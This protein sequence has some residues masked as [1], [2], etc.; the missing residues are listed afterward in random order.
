M[1]H[2]DLSARLCLAGILTTLGACHEAARHGGDA[3]GEAAVTGRL[4]QSPRH[5]EWVDIPTDAGRTVR[6][7]V[8]Y[9]QVSHPTL[10]VVIIHENR[11]LNEWARSVT[12]QVA[13]AG[14]VAIAPDLLSGNDPG[15]G[16]T[17]RFTSSDAAREVIY[18][19]PP[20]Q[21]LSDLDAVVSHVRELKATTSKVVVAG[22]CWG[23]S[24]SFRYAGHSADIE[25]AFVFYGGPPNPEAMKTIQAPVYGF[26]GGNDHRI[27]ASVPDVSATMRELGNEYDPVIYEGA[28]H[29]FMRGGES[30]DATPA[31]RQ[32]RSEA[33][34]RFKALLAGL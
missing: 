32:A 31:N 3:Q 24:Q 15:E 12:D 10:A 22:F 33:W 11:G 34:Q 5:H 9:P 25:A 29:A 18:K 30:R 26:Y 28:G 19:L 4:D 1:K 27:T 2:L 6:A 23:G 20:Q 16:G 7:Y 17:E 8:A 13:E 21:V 14:Y